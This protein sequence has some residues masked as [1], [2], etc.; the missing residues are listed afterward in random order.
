MIKLLENFRLFI[1]ILKKKLRGK[2]I[3]LEQILYLFFPLSLYL[4]IVWF[5]C[6]SSSLSFSPIVF[7]VSNTLSLSLFLSDYSYISF[8]FT[9]SLSLFFLTFFLS[10]F[11][12]P[13]IN[14]SF[15]FS[16]VSLTCRKDIW[17]PITPNPNLMYRKCA[18]T[19][20]GVY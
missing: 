12:F 14:L 19:I 18:H 2:E 7:A 3:Y 5:L 15:S 11:I 13:V 8:Y 6:I 16:T 9:F 4:F 10:L 17:L 20:R 1:I